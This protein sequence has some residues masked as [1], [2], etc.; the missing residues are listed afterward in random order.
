MSLIG[1]DLGTSSIKVAA[2]AVDG[3]A[4]AAARRDVPGY[5]PEPGHWEVDVRE[6]RA[7][8]WSALAAV[9]AEKPRFLIIPG[10]LTKDGELVNHLLMAQKLARLEAQGVAQ[11]LGKGGPHQA[12]VVV[13]KDNE[14]RIG[15]EII[16][17]VYK[18]TGFD[19]N[20][21]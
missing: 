13:H 18:E 5:R 7:A 20:S 15:K 16:Q 4:L 8:F 17:S 6:S 9:A 1:I 3:T 11:E 2:Y 19:P 21:L 14:S 10:D 12:L